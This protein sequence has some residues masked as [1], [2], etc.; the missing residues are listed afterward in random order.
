[1]AISS[2]RGI[3]KQ[4]S[5]TLFALLVNFQSNLSSRGCFCAAVCESVVR[6]AWGSMQY[7]EESTDVGPFTMIVPLAMPSGPSRGDSL[8][9]EFCTV[10]MSLF[11]TTSTSNLEV[12]G[13]NLPPSSSVSHKVAV[14]SSAVGVYPSTLKVPLASR[15]MAR[16]ATFTRLPLASL[17][18]SVRFWASKTD[19]STARSPNSLVL[20]T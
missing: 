18:E 19:R 12:T 20:T 5:P 6:M 2:P 11:A 8:M 1:M 3:S 4:R 14:S 9:T 16:S 17:V 15:S 13:S 7:S 10:A